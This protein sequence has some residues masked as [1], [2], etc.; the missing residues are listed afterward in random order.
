[1][2][3]VLAI[4]EAVMIHEMVDTAMAGINP[5][6]QLYFP[7]VIVGA[8]FALVVG[9]AFMRFLLTLPPRT[10]FLMIFSGL[11]FVGG[12]VGMEVIAGFVFAAAENE[13]AAARSVSHV[14]AQAIEEAMEMAGVA[15]F[16]C[17]LL[18]YVN[19]SG[20]ELAVRRNALNQDMPS[21]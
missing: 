17:A 20:L 10:R 18:D 21:E 15:I 6:D 1:L 8:I 2:F 19:V 13:L 3:F 12:A 14:I 9:L 4:D 11:V 16:F 7:W 5:F